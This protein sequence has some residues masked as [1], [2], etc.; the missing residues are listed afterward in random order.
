M[1]T[2]KNQTF[3]ACISNRKEAVCR[4]T[5]DLGSSL[6]VGGSVVGGASTVV[7]VAYYLVCSLKSMCFILIGCC[8]SEL[9]AIH[10]PIVMYGLHEAV[11][12]FFTI[13]TRFTKLFTYL[14]GQ[15]KR[16]LSQH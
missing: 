6:P 11:Y 3:K 10:V 16:S 13:T 7:G 5:I 15:S 1:E 12:C 2:G 14:Y 8:V 9:Q 4:K